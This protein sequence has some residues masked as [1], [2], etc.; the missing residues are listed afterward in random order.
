MTTQSGHKRHFLQGLIKLPLER[1]RFPK[2]AKQLSHS[3][4][5]TFREGLES[6]HSWRAI[7]KLQALEMT[8]ENTSLSAGYNF[9]FSKVWG[10][11]L[12]ID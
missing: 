1:W 5:Q 2:F 3:P 11:E 7:L 6:R 4:S 9:R 8:N 10:K 12:G